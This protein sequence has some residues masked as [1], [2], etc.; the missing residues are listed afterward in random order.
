MIVLVGLQGSGRPP[1]RR[2]SPATSSTTAAPD[3]WSPPTG[4]APPRSSSSACSASAAGV[5]VWTGGT[6]P[7]TAATE[8]IHEAERL[9]KQVVIVDT[10]GRLQVDADLMAEL[11]HLVDVIHP[12][13]VLLT[14]DAMIGQDAVR[15]RHRVRRPGPLTGVVL[16]KLDGDARGGAA[17]SVKEVT[18]LPILF[19]GIGEQLDDFE[20]F[21][22]DRWPSRILGM[23]D[24]LTLIEKAEA[25]FDADQAHAA[26][27]KLRCRTVHPRGLPRPDAPDEEDGPAPEH[28]RDAPRRPEG[29]PATPSS[30]RASSAGSRPSSAP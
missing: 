20:P 2:S 18:G 11:A 5:P 29:A 6:D 26:E 13:D 10:A 24:V 8:G 1:R 21:Y 16:T 12:S 7:V 30:T 4:S 28:R 22:P 9:G 14:V 27:E 23:G 19:A 25:A 17:L 15:R 3:C